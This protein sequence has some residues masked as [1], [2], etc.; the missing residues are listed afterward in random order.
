MIWAVVPVKEIAGA[1]QRLSPALSPEQRDAFARV[2]LAEVLGALAGARGLAGVLLVT[3]EPFARDLAA[4]HGFRVT[5]EGAR[6]GHTGAVEAGRRLLA[7]EG[8]AG[9]VTMPGDIPAVTSA[10][11]E[12]VLAAHRAPGFTIVPAHDEQGSNA[13]CVS[14]PLAVKLRF[15]DNSYFPHLDAARAAGFEPRILPLPGI[16][17]DVDNPVDLEKLL[18]LPEAQGTRSVAWLRANA[19]AWLRAN[20]R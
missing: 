7:R 17:M 18:A 4:R 14:P 8:A 19:G 12:T 9:F 16:G 5:E 13:V 20:L 6:D 2:M 10:E 1:K 15:G 11:I 3:L